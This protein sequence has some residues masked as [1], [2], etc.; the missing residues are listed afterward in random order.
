MHFV[1]LAIRIKHFKYHIF[2]GMCSL[3]TWFSLQI[4]K[5]CMMISVNE[6][7]TSLKQMKQMCKMYA[8][9]KTKCCYIFL[10]TKKIELTI[11]ETFNKKNSLQNLT[12]FHVGFFFVK[13]HYL[14]LI[15]FKYCGILSL[16]TIKRIISK[17]IQAT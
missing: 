5:F 1:H 7:T 17:K 8:I 2:I 12:R 9:I 16:K 10:L 13:N 6:D 14:N 3:S 11:L 4:L 15:F